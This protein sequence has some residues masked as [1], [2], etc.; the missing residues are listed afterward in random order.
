MQPNLT[1][2]IPRNRA[3]VSVAIIT[4]LAPLALAACGDDSAG[5]SEAYTAFCDAELEVEAATLGED[6]AAIEAAFTALATAAPD[7]DKALV[8]RTIAAAQEMLS[9][10]GPPSEEFNAAYGDLVQVV[11]DECG[12]GKRSMRRRLTTRSRE[13]VTA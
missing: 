13:S 12:F 5:P 7:S 2:S 11:K 6:P 8:E 1:R 10:E 3:G 9:S 4:I